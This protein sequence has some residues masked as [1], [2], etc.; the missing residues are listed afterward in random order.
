FTNGAN[1]T[2][3]RFTIT[4]APRLAGAVRISSVSVRPTAAHRAGGTSVMGVKLT[5]HPAYDVKIMSA[6]GANITTV[7][8]Q[9]VAAGDVR[10]VWNGKDQANRAVPAGTYIVQI[11]ATGPDGESVKVIQPFAMLR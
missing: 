7:A 2:S 5:G 4:A 1:Q 10:L 6:T 3:R 11:R 8:S 9:D